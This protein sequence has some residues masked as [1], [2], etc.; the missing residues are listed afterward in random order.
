MLWCGKK[1]FEA[2]QIEVFGDSIRDEKEV[3]NIGE[4]IGDNVTITYMAKLSDNVYADVKPSISSLWWYKASSLYNDF[5]NF[6]KWNIRKRKQWRI[7][8]K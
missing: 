5:K 2:F 7:L 3:A 6:N 4:L 1:L 8:Y